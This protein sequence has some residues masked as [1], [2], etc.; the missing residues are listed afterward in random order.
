MNRWTERKTENILPPETAI[1]GIDKKDNFTRSAV[2][3]ECLA[4]KYRK[5]K[6]D[7]M[8]TTVISLTPQ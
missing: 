1:A 8:L 4:E 2:H 7:S 3:S 5:L 6:T